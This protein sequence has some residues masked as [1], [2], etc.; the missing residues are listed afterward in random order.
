MN[1]FR[2]EIARVIAEAYSP[3]RVAKLLDSAK[4]LVDEAAEALE[5]LGYERI[6]DANFVTLAPLAIGLRN[7]YTEPL[8]VS[9]SWDPY[10]NLPFIPGSSLKGA[11]ASL[12]WARNSKWYE[13]L[14]GEGEE[15]RSASPVIFLDACPA[16]RGC[17]G[18]EPPKRGHNQPPLPRG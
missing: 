2:R 4:K 3:E 10:M 8:E 15:R 16:A 11:V 18:Q 12:A 5:E 9:I 14:R 6:V 17:A 7:P 13:L 1:E